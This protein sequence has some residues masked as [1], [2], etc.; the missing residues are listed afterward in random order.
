[1]KSTR[2]SIPNSPL[3]ADCGV[4]LFSWV[5]CF[6][7]WKQQLWWPCSSCMIHWCFSIPP[8]L[9]KETSWSDQL[10]LSSKYVSPRG[11]TRSEPIAWIA[12][13]RQPY[14]D[15]CMHID[16]YT[17]M[18]LSLSLHAYAFQNAIA[19]HMYFYMRIY[20]WYVV[21]VVA[22]LFR[23]HGIVGREHLGA[24]PRKSRAT[25]P[26]PLLVSSI[27][28]ALNLPLWPPAPEK[29]QNPGRWTTFW[30]VAATVSLRF[31]SKKESTVNPYE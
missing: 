17:Y 6:T 4:H 1:M 28:G 29:Q 20:T 24:G 13:C 26:R 3:A 16:R 14:G 18:P 8:W 27:P 5:W 22:V 23:I 7:W 15:R 25:A 2:Q 9:E 21:H 19:L 11:W 31:W 10:L 30:S 12:G